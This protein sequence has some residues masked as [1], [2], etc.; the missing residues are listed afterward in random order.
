MV[1]NNATNTSNPITVAQ[2]GTGLATLTSHALQVGN[3]TGTITQLGVGATGTVLAGVTSGDPSFT[4][5]PSVTSITLS[6]GSAFDT[7]VEGTFLPVLNFGGAHVGITYNTQTGQYTQIGNV[8]FFTINIVLTNNGSSTGVATISGFPVA[9][10]ATTTRGTIPF[11]NNF[12]FSTNYTAAFFTS[13]PSS[14]IFSLNQSGPTV[15]VAT[16]SD[17]NFSNTTGLRFSGYYL[18]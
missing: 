8:V 5:T 11:T 12:T 9:G 13:A 17:T 4:A 3:G 7:Y 15:N 1:T 2:G 14:T 16:I 18:T 6:G 10:S